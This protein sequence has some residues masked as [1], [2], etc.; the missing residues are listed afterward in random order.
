MYMTEWE[1]AASRGRGQ[2]DQALGV[3]GGV[4]EV[5]VVAEPTWSR[6]ISFDEPFA[7]P[8]NALARPERVEVEAAAG[9]SVFHH[10]GDVPVLN[11]L[12][13][14]ALE[15]LAS[16][17]RQHDE[18]RARIRRANALHPSELHQRAHHIAD[19]GA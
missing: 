2:V 13:V 18:P 3:V 5:K 11:A 6:P 9:E 19:H 8:P 12:A 14:R 4:A 10:A 17:S 15:K 16:F 1:L 7:I